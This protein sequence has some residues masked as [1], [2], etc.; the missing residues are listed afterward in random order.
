[1][2]TYLAVVALAAASSAHAAD[3]DPRQWI[4]CLQQ[5][6]N[7]PSIPEGKRN[8]YWNVIDGKNTFGM[9]CGRQ[10]DT[11][12]SL[13]YAFL[14]ESGF[15]SLDFPV[16]QVTKKY[17][18]GTESPKY[19]GKVV[20]FKAGSKTYYL[21]IQFG[22]QFTT[23]PSEELSSASSKLGIAAASVKTAIAQYNQEISKKG[24]STDFRL[25]DT[26]STDADWVVACVG[27]RVS[28][29]LNLMMVPAYRSEF[30]T[31]DQIN[32]DRGLSTQSPEYHERYGRTVD[33]VKVDLKAKMMQTIPACAS[34]VDDQVFSDAFVRAFDAGGVAVSNYQMMHKRVN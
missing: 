27:D 9:Q 25:K 23:I 29:F 10:N 34:V 3:T 1:M 5:L 4:N 14:N 2:K 8:A 11:N 33:Q 20:T 24:I 7:Q 19:P 30:P 21:G 12:V 26:D 6:Q 13:R 18:W 32:R 16:V 22:D 28:D 17:S 31:N 15:K